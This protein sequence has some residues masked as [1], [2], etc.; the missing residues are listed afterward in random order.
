[1]ES[2]ITDPQH[3][4]QGLSRR[5]IASLAAWGGDNGAK[6]ASLQVEAANTPARTLYD[7]FGLKTELYRYHY[8][9]ASTP[10]DRDAASAYRFRT[11]W[12]RRPR[13]ASPSCHS[14]LTVDRFGTMSATMARLRRKR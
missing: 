5:I 12:R 7:S 10:I 3:R 2:V 1:Y 8:R 9:R 6:A 11:L 14:R 13:T 4:R